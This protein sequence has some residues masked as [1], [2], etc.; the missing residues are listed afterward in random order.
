MAPPVATARTPIFATPAEARRAP[1]AAHRAAA[2]GFTLVELMV[3]LAIAAL[4]IAVVPP[5]LQKL[6]EGMAYRDTV[7]SVVTGLRAARERALVEG[8][9]TRFYVDLAGRRYG[10]DPQALRALPESLQMHVIVA[11]I[12]MSEASGQRL[13]AI[14]FLPQGGATGGSV[15]VLRPGVGGV[16]ITVD[17]L[18]AAVSQ[19]PLPS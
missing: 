5:S 19:T 2:R 3:A 11:G 6:R 17:W 14:R 10:P 7:R 15:D 13:A 1:R 8:R 12:E 18:S 9:E 16:R 4:A